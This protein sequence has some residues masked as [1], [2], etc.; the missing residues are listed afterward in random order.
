MTLSFFAANIEKSSRFLDGGVNKSSS[1]AH[2]AQVKGMGWGSFIERPPL[3]TWSASTRLSLARPSQEPRAADPA[4]TMRAQSLTWKPLG[5]R[6][7]TS[8]T[9]ARGGLRASSI[10]GRAAAQFEAEAK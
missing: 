6:A 5:P 1:Q 7:G 2:K 9:A 4:R 10:V 3:L 8:Y